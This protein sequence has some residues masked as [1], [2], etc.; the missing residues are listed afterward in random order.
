MSG[1][2]TI[3]GTG[4]AAPAGRVG[5]GAGPAV[6]ASAGGFT[7]AAEPAGAGRAGAA[8]PVAPALLDGMLALQEAG[9]DAVRDREARRRGEDL[10]AELR[11]LQL[12]L[13]AAAES[14][15]LL[16]RLAD[17]AAALPE[18]ADPALRE[19]V[20][21]IALRARVELARLELARLER[22]SGG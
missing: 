12:A 21:A 20:G 6:G 8:G 3:G 1:I 10:L 11:R 5:G 13:L 15:G 17:L 2:R 7:V 9:S 14:P 22:R 16:Q 18:A 4:H 19:A